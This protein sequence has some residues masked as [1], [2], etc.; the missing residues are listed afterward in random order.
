M[1]ISADPK[2][3]YWSP[4][5]MHSTVFVDGVAQKYCTLADDEQG[6]VERY[7]LDGMG[8]LFYCGENAVMDTVRGQVDIIYPGMDFETWMCARTECAHADSCAAL[9]TCQHEPARHH[10]D[11]VG[12]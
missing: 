8:N 10:H 5:S 1:R 11:P 6:Y 7:A 9:R 4:I 3:P 12:R 2:S